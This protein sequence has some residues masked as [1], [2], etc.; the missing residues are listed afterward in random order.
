MI[1]EKK[2]RAILPILVSIVLFM[3]FLDISIINTAIP[4]IARNFAINPIFLKF[5]IASYFL[6]L[7]IFIPISGWCNDKFGTKTIFLFS[8]WLFTA[9]SLLCS[10]SHNVAQ[11]TVFRFLQGIGGAFMNPV[12]RLIILRLFPAKEL[13]KIQS[14]I[15]TP[16]LVG[17]VIGP[18]LG[19]IITN[20]LS[21]H[22]IFNINIPIGI[23]ALYVGFKYIT[24]MK[25]AT[26]SFDWIGF[27]IASLS[28]ALITFFIEM[29]N[30]YE[31]ISKA[32]VIYSGVLGIGLGMLLILY[33]MKKENAVFNFS[34]FK[35]KSFNI[36]F[37]INFSTFALLSSISFLLPLMLQESYHY[38]P[39]QSGL[40]VLPIAIAQVFSRSMA[41]KLIHKF[42]FK[43][44]LIFAT[45]FVFVCVFLMGTI[46]EDSSIIYIVI[47]E[48]FFGIT[49]MMCGSST[50]A[51]N[52]IDTPK[53]KFSAVTSLDITFRQFSSSLGIGFASLCLTSFANYSNIT[54]FGNGSYKIFHYT[55]YVLS[56]L[57][58]IALFNAFRLDRSTGKLTS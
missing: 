35:V 41:P 1:N 43:N 46:Y 18:F 45:S 53:D 4:S 24:Q 54:L 38:N 2:A 15:F 10:V 19:G 11:L 52:Y 37:C 29:L 8:V 34:I 17:L 32:Q 12:S 23:I 20:Y 25:V 5:S 16:A 6:S 26:T 22:W 48:V 55:F 50:G 13:V 57:A 56:I 44:L 14:I 51:L 27:I 31:V 7:A 30:H 49:I 9:A 42:G 3:E 39:A 36:G 40:L 28:L 21:W 33:C 47:I 58:I